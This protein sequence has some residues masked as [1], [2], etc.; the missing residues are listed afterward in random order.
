M[1]KSDFMAD[2]ETI[3]KGSRSGHEG[4]GQYVIRDRTMWQDLWE[5]VHSYRT[6]KPDL[7]EI[8]FEHEMVIAYFMGS[9]R[10]SG[11]SAEIIKAE[12]TGDKLKVAVRTSAPKTSCFVACWLTQP[13]HIVKTRKT[14]KAVEFV[15]S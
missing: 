7:P 5:T 1:H 8:D 6:D 15:I 2:L 12:E 3:A 11:Y 4:Q 10:S 14:D 13:Y 9:R